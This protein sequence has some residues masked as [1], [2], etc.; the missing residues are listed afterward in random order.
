VFDTLKGQPSLKRHGA[1]TMPGPLARISARLLAMAT[2]IRH[3]QL[4]GPGTAAS[5]WPTTTDP[6][7]TGPIIGSVLVGERQPVG[8]IG[9]LEDAVDL[10]G[11]AQ[12]R[13]ATLLA[14][15]GSHDEQADAGRVD[16]L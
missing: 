8:E 7:D 15:L 6:I 5:S 4:A 13:E 12:E 11:A 2:A 3:N 9:D 10:A 14:A 16:E 1:R